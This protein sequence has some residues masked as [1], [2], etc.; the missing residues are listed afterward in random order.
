MYRLDES[1]IDLLKGH[2]GSRFKYVDV[3]RPA[4]FNAKP[5]RHEVIRIPLSELKIRAPAELDLESE[6]IVYGSTDYE[7]AE[8]ELLLEGLGFKGVHAFEG[9]FETI[10]RFGLR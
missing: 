3:R 1:W 9:G 2:A 10:S 8:A 5:P 4:E 6:L 7:S